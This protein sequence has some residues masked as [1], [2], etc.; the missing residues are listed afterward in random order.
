MVT[1]F[2]FVQ[3]QNILNGSEYSTWFFFI[4]HHFAKLKLEI[5]NIIDKIIIMPSKAKPVYKGGERMKFIEMLHHKSHCKIVFDP[6]FDFILFFKLWNVF[7][8]TFS[9]EEIRT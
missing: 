9:V 7:S 5:V 2:I 8:L 3:V 6:L 4:L 1:L